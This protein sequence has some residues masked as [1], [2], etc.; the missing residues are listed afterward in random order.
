M[1]EYPVKKIGHY[2][3]LD[4][5]RCQYCTVPLSIKLCLIVK[6][7]SCN[8]PLPP[9]SVYGIHVQNEGNSWSKTTNHTPQRNRPAFPHSLEVL[10]KIAKALRVDIKELF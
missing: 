10:E 4:T 5:L 2:I 6:Y 8:I 1:Q 3:A 9:V 7:D